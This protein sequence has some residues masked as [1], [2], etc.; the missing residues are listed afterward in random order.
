MFSIFY[1]QKKETFPKL[2]IYLILC[3]PLCAYFNI[4]L[5]KFVYSSEM[6]AIQYNS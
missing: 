5:F 4:L 3:L 2:G 6:I 1:K